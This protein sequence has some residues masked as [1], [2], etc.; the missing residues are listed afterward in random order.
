MIVSMFIAGKFETHQRFVWCCIHCDFGS[1]RKKTTIV[2]N[3]TAFSRDVFSF[4]FVAYQPLQAKAQPGG[5]EG[6]QA[7][8]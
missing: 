8:P 4:E 1:F 2:L 7:P 3:G 6:A 5:A